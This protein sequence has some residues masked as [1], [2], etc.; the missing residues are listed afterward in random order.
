MVKTLKN[1]DPATEE[2]VA[3]LTRLVNRTLIAVGDSPDFSVALEIVRHFVTVSP[4]EAEITT[5]I[6]RDLMTLRPGGHLGARS[7][8]P[9]NVKLNMRKLVAAVAGGVFTT[10]GVLQVPWT[11]VLGALVVWDTLYSAATLELSEREA[12]VMWTLWQLKDENHTVS[13]AGLLEYVNATRKQFGRNEL[14]RQELKDALTKLEQMGTIK[15]CSRDK[16]RWWLRE[17]VRVAY[18]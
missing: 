14:S 16:S 18:E 6:T 1:N 11:A 8:K 9:G 4:P 5:E 10:V 13:D 7:V 3:E 12:A 2:K 15:R 17:W